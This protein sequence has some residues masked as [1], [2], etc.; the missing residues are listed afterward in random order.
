[1]S[2]TYDRELSIREQVMAHAAR[3]E[4]EG[5]RFLDGKG[6]ITHVEKLCKRVEFKFIDGT[7]YTLSRMDARKLDKFQFTLR[8]AIN[9][10]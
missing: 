7:I 9:N 5:V 4:L 6:R 1:M 10:G 3:I 8:P 2:E